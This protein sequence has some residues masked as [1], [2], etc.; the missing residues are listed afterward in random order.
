[1]PLDLALDLAHALD[2]V[3]FVQ[4]LQL[5]SMARIGPP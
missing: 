5:L 2:P 1:M 3:A 4:L